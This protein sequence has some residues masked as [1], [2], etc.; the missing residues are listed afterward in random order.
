VAKAAPATVNVPLA[1]Q[2]ALGECFGLGPP[3]VARADRP[4]RAPR[5]LGEDEVRRLLR[6]ARRTGSTRDRALLALLSGTG[7]RL[8]EAAAL[9]VDDVPTTERTGAVHVRAGKRKRPRTVPLPADARS[10]LR[11]RLTERAQHPAA[12]R[13][14]P[15]LW[16][17]RRGRLSARQLQHIVGQ[18]EFREC[19]EPVAV[20]DLLDTPPP[21][22][23]QP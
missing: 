23:S 12:L 10:R 11:C 9:D 13:G 8:A 1:A 15:A 3:D 4:A 14:E 21:T 19:S 16:L 17:G 18:L 20:T 6:A 5:A 22:T 7:L 2:V